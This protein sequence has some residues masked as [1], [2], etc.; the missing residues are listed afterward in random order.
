MGNT[1]ITHLG[2]QREFDAIIALCKLLD[3]RVGA[4][5]LGSKL[6]ALKKTSNNVAAE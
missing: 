1:G 3:V 4:R 5:L 2:K 6:V